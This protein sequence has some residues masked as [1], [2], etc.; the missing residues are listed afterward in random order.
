MRTV[1]VVRENESLILS[2]YSSVMTRRVER[3]IK[4]TRHEEMI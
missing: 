4:E 2:S 1:Y 3:E